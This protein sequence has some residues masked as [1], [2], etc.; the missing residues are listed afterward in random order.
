MASSAATAASYGH[1]MLARVEVYSAGQRPLHHICEVP[2][3]CL[4]VMSMAKDKK[5][6]GTE[7]LVC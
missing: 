2:N 1:N 4:H 3:L 5:R 7:V 6:R